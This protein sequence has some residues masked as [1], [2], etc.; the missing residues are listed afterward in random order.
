MA[1]LLWPIFSS[2]F[3]E[4]SDRWWTEVNPWKRQKNPTKAMRVAVCKGESVINA[5]SNI[6]TNTHLM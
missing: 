6:A 4:S 2:A 3:F 1:A 5:S